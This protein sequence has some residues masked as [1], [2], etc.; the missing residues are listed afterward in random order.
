MALRRGLHT[1]NRQAVQ[2][3]RLTLE[4]KH[5]GGLSGLWR[6]TYN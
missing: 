2:F 3:V 4:G 5:M 1:Y 6:R